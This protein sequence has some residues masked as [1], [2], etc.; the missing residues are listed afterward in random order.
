MTGN[1]YLLLHGMNKLHF[2]Y[3]VQTQIFVISIFTTESSYTIHFLEYCC[4]KY[5]EQEAC[6]FHKIFPVE[7]IYIY[8]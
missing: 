8:I 6:P 3:F 1:F 4:S 5:P 2:I 7:T